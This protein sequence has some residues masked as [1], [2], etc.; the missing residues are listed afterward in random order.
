MPL[1]K[2]IDTKLVDKEMVS[3]KELVFQNLIN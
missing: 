2:C 3:D 1:I